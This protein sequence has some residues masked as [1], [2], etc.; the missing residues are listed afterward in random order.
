MAKRWTAAAATCETSLA[1]SHF[2]RGREVF[3]ARCVAC[4]GTDGG[5]TMAAPPLWG[6]RSYNIGA[7][8]A[9]VRTAAAFIRQLMPRDRPGSLTPQEAF[10]VATY[11]NTRARPDFR[12]K[13]LDWP[14]GG[15]P[16]DVAYKTLSANTGAS[17]KGGH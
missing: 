15:A 8:M 13:E 6:S 14:H 17:G 16:P 3:S 11:I 5:G 12:G 10:D 4:H 9:R 2:S 1:T 7:G